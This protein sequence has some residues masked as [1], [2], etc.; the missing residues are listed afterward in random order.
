ML[1][2]DFVGDYIEFHK[3][4]RSNRNVKKLV[5]VTPKCGYGDV[6]RGL[7]TS[8]YLAVLS[9]R[10]LLIESFGYH[11]LK[12]LISFPSNFLHNEE[13]VLFEKENRENIFYYSAMNNGS[14]KDPHNFDIY[15]MYL[16]ASEFDTVKIEHSFESELHKILENWHWMF[17]NQTKPPRFCSMNQESELQHMLLRHVFQP[18]KE[19]I[20][21]Y[22]KYISLM[23]LSPLNYVSVHARIGMGTNEELNE[24]FKLMNE[25][26]KTVARC[27]ARE[28]YLRLR[29][30]QTLSIPIFL[31]T[32]SPSFRKTFEKAIMELNSTVKVVHP[33]W[34]HTG[35]IMREDTE[36][37]T[38]RR[39]INTF[40]ELLVLGDANYIIHLYSGFPILAYRIGESVSRTQVFPSGCS[41]FSITKALTI[42]EL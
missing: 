24:R 28:S 2:K 12:S 25:N 11:N 5:Y 17:G 36:Q 13:D 4:Y 40:A 29:S 9:R 15:S 32:D 23:G 35:H 21:R 6:F 20:K 34:E 8:Y 38:L 33:T 27:L 41:S 26:L 30:L 42:K 31:S 3:K 18:S 37:N 19:V 14:K 39:A 7:L 22:E 16:V 10:I 1:V